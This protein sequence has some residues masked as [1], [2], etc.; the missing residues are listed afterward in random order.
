MG[1]IWTLYIYIAV[2]NK[3]Y[4]AEPHVAIFTTIET[5]FI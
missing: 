4:E 2:S 1:Y 5:C 3:I